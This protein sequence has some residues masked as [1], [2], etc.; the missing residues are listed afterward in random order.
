MMIKRVRVIWNILYEKRYIITYILLISRL[1]FKAYL[2]THKAFLASSLKM[3][4]SK[5]DNLGIV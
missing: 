5:Y 2:Q 3:E 1:F 4:K